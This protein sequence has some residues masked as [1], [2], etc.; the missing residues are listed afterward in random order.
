MAPD[1]RSGVSGTVDAFNFIRRVGFPST[2]RVL[3]IFSAIALL[4]A[5]FSLLPSNENLAQTLVFVGAVLVWPAFLREFLIS[6]L[7]LNIAMVL[8]YIWLIGIELYV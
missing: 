6:T 2:P 7:I 4:S 1:R 8:D 3:T 5:S